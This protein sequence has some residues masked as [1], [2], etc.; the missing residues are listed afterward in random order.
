M[1]SRT[2]VTDEKGLRNWLVAV[3]GRRRL[4]APRREGDIV[5]LAQVSS[6]DEV[7][8]DFG[9][10]RN[11]PREV[12]F[13]LSEDLFSF[14]LNGRAISIEPPRSQPA[15]TLL[16]GI[17]ACDARSLAITDAVFNELGGRK[18]GSYASRRENTVLAVLW[19][20][21]VQPWCRCG[22]LGSPLESARGHAD[23]LI[24]P[25]G[26]S[27]AF[28]AFTEKGASLVSPAELFS[29]A[30]QEQAARRD[31]A[32]GKIE[33]SAGRHPALTPVEEDWDAI[34]DNPVW[35]EMGAR[36]LGCGVCTY[37]CP[38]CT[39]FD[40]LDECPGDL[41]RRY[42]CWDSCQFRL[43]TVHTSGHNPRPDQASRVRQRILH[44]FKSG[45][46]LTGLIGCV[47]CGRCLELCPAGISYVEILE[48]LKQAAVA[49]AAPAGEG[50]A[51]DG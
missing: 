9:I 11:S 8:L 47:G 30:S 20:N 38:A 49:P 15:E 18:D 39:C 37:L 22:S 48:R 28:D 12:F 41:G 51:K 26:D 25:L 34:W 13:P 40:I 21:S 7:V 43:F 35:K 45:P 27:F 17:R 5:L 23:I 50:A 16:F 46:A 3:A 6:A 36:C 1:E 31:E 42:K 14:R 10:T 33:E 2:L 19:C 29:P 32:Y 4:I 24:T 44:K